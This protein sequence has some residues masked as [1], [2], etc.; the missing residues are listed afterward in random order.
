[1]FVLAHEMFHPLMHNVHCDGPRNDANA[2][3][4]TQAQSVECMNA[5]LL[6]VEAHDCT[7]H[8]ADAPIR[9]EYEFLEAA[10]FPVLADGSAGPPAR[11]TPVRRLM[12]IATGYGIIRSGSL[13]PLDP[14]VADIPL[15]PEDA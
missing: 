2:G 8:V 1:M 13:T 3:S 6:E 4:A 12:Q 7:K 14:A 15:R 5:S 10:A 9:A 11:T